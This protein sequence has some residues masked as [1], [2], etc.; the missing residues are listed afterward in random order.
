MSIIKRGEVWHYAFSIKGKR[1]RGSTHTTDKATAQRIDAKLRLEAAVITF[2]RM[3]GG[4]RPYNTHY[5][6]ASD[7]A[8]Q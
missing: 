4:R 3:K 2:R 7:F 6:F 1:F 8:G 5:R